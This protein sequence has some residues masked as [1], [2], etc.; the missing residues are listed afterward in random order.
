MLPNRS[1][2]PLSMDSYL[3]AFLK[4]QSKTCTRCDCSRQIV[5]PEQRRCRRWSKPFNSTSQHPPNIQSNK[6][7]K[8]NS[9]TTKRDSPK[10]RNSSFVIAYS[11]LCISTK[12][13]EISTANKRRLEKAGKCWKRLLENLFEGVS[14]GVLPHG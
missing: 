7:K 13:N 2:P 11:F 5:Y 12:E 8:K 9:S 3:S 14:M 10:G 1:I 4:H 6:A